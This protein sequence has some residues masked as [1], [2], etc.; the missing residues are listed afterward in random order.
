MVVCQNV[1]RTAIGIVSRGGASAAVFNGIHSG[2]GMLIVGVLNGEIKLFIIT[3]YITFYIIEIFSNSLTKFYISFFYA[4][5]EHGITMWLNPF[6][7]T[8]FPVW[9]AAATKILFAVLTITS[10]ATNRQS[11]DLTLPCAHVLYCTPW[12]LGY[13][14]VP[15]ETPLSTSI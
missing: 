14:T 8:T 6:F 11:L 1:W 3:F 13:P 10:L 4:F 7:S 5:F 12:A 15:P 9:P 2:L